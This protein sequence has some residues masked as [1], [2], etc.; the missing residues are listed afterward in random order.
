[1][2]KNSRVLNVKSRLDSIRTLTIFKKRYGN[3]APVKSFQLIID[4]HSFELEDIEK[5]SKLGI[6]L[7]STFI[8]ALQVPETIKFYDKINNIHSEEVFVLK[9]IK[10][11][12][13]G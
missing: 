7:N 8:N 10:T 1:M 12:H 11:R 5:Y 2:P 3:K 13:Q 4:G 6:D 9:K